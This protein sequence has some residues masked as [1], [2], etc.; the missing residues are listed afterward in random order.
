MKN[1]TKVQIDSQN[2]KKIDSKV[3][4]HLIERTNWNAIIEENANN[5]YKKIIEEMDNIYDRA[6]YYKQNK[7]RRKWYPWITNE[8]LDECRQRDR[9]YKKWYKD[10]GNKD[11]E[12]AYKKFRNYVTLRLKKSKT[13]YYRNKFYISSGNI[14]N[15]WNLVNEVLSRNKKGSGN[16][17]QNFKLKDNEIAEKFADVFQNEV[18]DIKHVCVKR[19]N[20][21]NLNTLTNTIYLDAATTDEVY[22]IL[23]C[24]NIHK[25]PG[26]DNIRPIDLKKHAYIFAPVITKL[27][28]ATIEEGRIPDKMKIAIIRPC[29]KAGN[30]QEMTNYRPISILP[31]IDKILEDIV[32]HKINNFLN[33]HNII[34]KRQY[35][36]QAGKT[37]NKLLGEFMDN[38]YKAKSIK[39]HSLII[40]IDFK[41]A[42]DT[43]DHKKILNSIETLGLRGQCLDWMKDYL[44]NRKYTVKVNSNYSRFVNIET[45]V[46]QGSKLG[47][48]LFILMTNDLYDNLD[49]AEIFA[50]A[51]DLAIIT[52]NQ[53]LKNA[54]EDMQCTV[55]Q[56]VK[57]AHDKGLI[58]NTT[59]TKAMHIAPHMT[60]SHILNVHI[61]DKPCNPEQPSFKKIE[62]V[63]EFKYLG[64]ILDENL[65]WKKHIDYIRT[66]IR[67]ISYAMYH[68]KDKCNLTTLKTVYHAL[69]ESQL[70]FGITAWGH[71]T[72]CKQLQICNNRLLTTIKLKDQ[73]HSIE[74]L[75][76]MTMINTFYE[77]KQFLKKIDHDI[78]TRRKMNEKY[79]THRCINIFDECTLRNQ[80][81]KIFNELPKELINIKDINKRKRQIKIY[82]SNKLHC[83]QNNNT[84]R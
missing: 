4:D 11:K 69:A 81:P 67:K 56:V 52:Q 10:R 55:N 2:V 66:K 19:I 46:P 45:G 73:V 20:K 51:D 30:K 64:I 57:W 59:K 13:D 27:I 34:N 84:K 22:R 25:G 18:T 15:T 68:L 74:T 5:I 28:N 16:V 49:K 75:Y 37:I 40:F 63:K 78:K 7:N 72:H 39:Q 42:F 76:K 79:Q 21:Q 61:P 8:I 33:K 82:F 17:E 50:Y 36:F 3:V 71:S 53:V 23:T 29:F 77:D 60:K 6:S 62:T 43:M 32:I 48:L 47:P 35:G 26:I 41:K 65:N 31:T 80:L 24:L 14:K 9:L 83:N 70:R 54:E 12:S 38:L 58:I 44:N 1:T